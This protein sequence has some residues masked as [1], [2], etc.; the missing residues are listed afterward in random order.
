MLLQTY[1]KEPRRALVDSS[2][3]VM[4][5]RG[6]FNR[7]NCCL[8][9]TTDLRSGVLGSHLKVFFFQGWQGS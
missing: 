8:L 5:Q 7:V 4:A 2:A 3:L 9:A 1:A 6:V